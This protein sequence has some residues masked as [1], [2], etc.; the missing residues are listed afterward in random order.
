MDGRGTRLIV[1]GAGAAMKQLQ[2][3]WPLRRSLGAAPRVINRK[4]VDSFV[5][6]SP[7]ALH[8]ILHMFRHEADGGHHT[9]EATAEGPEARAIGRCHLRSPYE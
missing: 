5:V 4:M 7:A 2:A 3:P 6:L 9:N 1:S 8:M